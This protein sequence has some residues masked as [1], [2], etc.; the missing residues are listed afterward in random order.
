MQH[1]LVLLPYAH[2]HFRQLYSAAQ[3]KFVRFQLI[4]T[5]DGATQQSETENEHERGSQ[6]TRPSLLCVCAQHSV[7]TTRIPK[8]LNQSQCS[9]RLSCDCRRVLMSRTK[10]KTTTNSRN[11]LHT[12]RTINF[13]Y[14]KGN[15][16]WERYGFC[17][18][19]FNYEQLKK[20]FDVLLLNVQLVKFQMLESRMYTHYIIWIRITA[21][22]Y[23]EKYNSSKQ[24][25][26]LRVLKCSF[27]WWLW[28]R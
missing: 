13:E 28:F 8:Q 7:Y 6:W 4:N 5:S 16:R 26:T 12:K 14:T 22:K 21:L 15:K 25:Q 11:A 10:I 18:D 1:Q 27:N 3:C 17:F 9:V 2:S 23:G 24:K 20:V 19:D